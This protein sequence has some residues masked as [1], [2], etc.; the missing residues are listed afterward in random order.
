MQKVLIIGGGGAGIILANHLDTKKFDVTLIDKSGDTFYQPW[1]LYIAFKGSTRKISRDISSLLKP[2]VK[3]VKDE[4][5]QID[6]DQ[7]K[8]Y[9]QKKGI[10]TYDYIAIAAGTSPDPDSMPGLREIYD[11]YGD[12]HTSVENSMKLWKHIDSFKGGTIAIGQASPTVKCPPSLLEGAFLLEELLQKKGLK[13]KSKIV[14][15]TPFPRAYS[16]EPMDR[17]VGPMVKERGIEIMTFFD[18]DEIDTKNKEIK[19]IEGDSIK[20]DLPI[21]VS[22]HKGTKIKILPESVKDEDRFIK[23]DKL[24]MRIEGYDNAFALGDCNNLPTSKTGVT[25]HLEAMA[26][27]DIMQGKEAQFSGRINC[28][29]DTAYGKATFVIADYKNPVVPYPPTKVK[30]FM[31]MS[32]ARIYWMTLK[33][34]ADP[35]F[36]YF[37]SY[38][39]PVKLN[40]KYSTSK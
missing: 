24:T 30:H 1:F 34:T 7:R 5:T 28:P 40:K 39:N 37:F 31:K 27:A 29:F 35:I 2:G 19:S 23:S 10:Y 38:T 6:L 11:E 25:A 14:F 12:Y 15:F 17:I 22:P 3:F 20:Y 36:E 8:V 13:E 33:G 9:G 26:A 18:F 4:I 16:A 32:M 21:I